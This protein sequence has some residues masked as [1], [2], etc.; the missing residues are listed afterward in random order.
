MIWE[1]HY[2]RVAGHFGVEKTL[3]VLQKYFYWPKL[4]QYISKYIRS[5]TSCSIDKPTIKKQGFYTPFPTPNGPRESILMDYKLGLPSTKHENN[6]VF[7]VVDQL[8]NMAI[9]IV[10]KKSITTEDIAK[11]FFEHVLVH[12]GLP[13]TIISDQDNRFVSTFW[14]ILWSLLD[15]KLTKSTTFHA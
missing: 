3:V 9:L 6:C 10:C 4:R 11:L 7:V 12:F 15:N 14:L 13:Q 8:S 2:N 1:S 5:Y